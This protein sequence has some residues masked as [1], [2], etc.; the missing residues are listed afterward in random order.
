M[1]RY[2]LILR[3]GR[4]TWLR[5]ISG[6]LL[7]PARLIKGQEWDNGPN[8]WVKP[9]HFLVDQWKQWIA[10]LSQASGTHVANVWGRGS[11]LQATHEVTFH[12]VSDGCSFD[13]ETQHAAVGG[14]EH[15]R[16]WFYELTPRQ[17][18]LFHITLVE[19]LGTVGNTLNFGPG[20]P[21]GD[22]RPTD[23]RPTV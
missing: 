13:A 9:Q 2:E 5:I 22:Q 14:F 1:A 6:P 23:I 7:T 11:H 8:T 12:W 17:A 3:Q 10:W 16:W 15:G 21:S 18:Q 20:V 19:A 4:A